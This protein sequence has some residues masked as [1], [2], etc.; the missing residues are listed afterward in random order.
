M[1]EIE[2]IIPAYNAH[3]TIKKTLES[4]WNQKDMPS[5]HVTIIND[6][7]LDYNEIISEYKKYPISEIKTPKNMGPGYSRQY[8]I[9]NTESKYIIFIDSDD[10]F[11]DNNSIT[12]LYN[13][14]ERYNKDIIIGEFIYKRDS[15][16]EIRKKDWIWLHGKIYRRKK[17]QEL[18][19]RF[20]D[21]RAN[22]DNGFNRQIYLTFNR[23]GYLNT[24]V[25][26]YEENEGSIT[27]KNNREYKYTGLEWYTYNINW[28]IE[29][30]GKNIADTG[31]LADTIINTLFNMYNYS[32]EF[33]EKERKENILRWCQCIY[34]RYEENKNICKPYI[35]LY[36]NKLKGKEKFYSFLEELKQKK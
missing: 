25:Y 14:I 11:Y 13:K 24:P 10:Y 33:S 18:N 28:A 34:K 27:R 3:K 36:A 9:D 4:I 31:R 7:G 12:L 5:F 29:K 23:I 8:G 20:N 21:T 30:A 22:E 26:V 32:L 6:C 19:I 16:K 17:L 2:I 35:E 15:I 1:N